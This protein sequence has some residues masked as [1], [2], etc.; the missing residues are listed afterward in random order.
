MPKRG[1]LFSWETVF[2][3][4]DR[5]LHKL[6]DWKITPGR[7]TAKAL[8]IEW[9]IRHQD[10]DGA[11]GGIQPPWIYSLMA[12]HASGYTH[13]HPVMAKGLAALD[14]DWSYERAGHRF[15]QA[16]ES[17]VWDTL[18]SLTSIQECEAQTRDRQLT[19][20]AVRWILAHENRTRGDWSHLTPHAE[21][22][23]WAFERANLHYP[24]LDDTAVAI[25][26]LARIKDP[27]LRH[28]AAA[29]LQRAINW[30][31]AMQSDNGGWGAFDRNN[32]STIITKIPFCDF[33]EV[34]DP[35]SADVTAHMVE[36]LAAAGFVKDHPHVAHAVEFLWS[37]QEDDGGWFGRWGVNYIYGTAA[38]LPALAEIGEDMTQPRVQRAEAWIINSHN[39]DGGWGETCASYMALELAGTGVSTASQ[40]A[41]ALIALLAGDNP[42]SAEALRRGLDFLITTQE[43]G[44]W[45][46]QHYT[47]TGFPGYGF[48][49]RAEQDGMEKLALIQGPELSRA[50]M[51][52]YNLYRHYFPLIALGRAR[53]RGHT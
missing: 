30:S 42:S 7:S 33:G 43:N 8:C 25:L 35:P 24:D 32:D 34:L 44:S 6:Q 31:L 49:A 19:A 52:N 16:C 22:G 50:F 27:T 9:I 40:T 53:Q 20:K 15:I 48:G 4:F 45:N 3:G 14:S 38:V 5:V 13:D 39:D 28:S 11:W 26:M 18:L 29:P 46:E 21:A 2:R 10:A 23:G 41:W 51:I 17:P 47:G 36:A 12:L 37:E 1:G